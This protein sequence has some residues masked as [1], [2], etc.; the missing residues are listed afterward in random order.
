MSNVMNDLH[1]IVDPLLVLLVAIVLVLL[2]VACIGVDVRAFTWLSDDR[3]QQF[4]EA[5][6]I[7]RQASKEFKR[8]QRVRFRSIRFW[9]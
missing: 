7:A 3:D 4:A 5:Q 1:Q 8:R 2:L 6:R 9:G